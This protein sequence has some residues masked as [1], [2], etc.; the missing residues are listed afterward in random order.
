MLKFSCD[1]RKNK[2]GIGSSY[3]PILPNGVNSFF[4]STKK[5]KGGEPPAENSATHGRT[6]DQGHRARNDDGPRRAERT[7]DDRRRTTSPSPARGKAAGRGERRE[8]GNATETAT[9]RGGTNPPPR[10]TEG[11]GRTRNDAERRRNHDTKRKENRT[12]EQRFFTPP[13]CFHRGVWNGCKG[14]PP[15]NQL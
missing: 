10:A 5:E 4:L 6:A 7:H 15:L 8:Q 13:L 1:I 12:K 11:Q 3:L 14:Q 9:T 2:Y